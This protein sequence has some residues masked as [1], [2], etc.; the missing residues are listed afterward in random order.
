MG[1]K[2]GLDTQILIYYFEDNKKY[3]EQVEAI[4]LKIRQGTYYGVFSIIGL[5]ELLTGP[6]QQERFDLAADYQQTL[7]HFPNLEIK[8]LTLALVDIASD[9]RAKYRLSTPDAIH[10]AT[11]IDFG[12]DKFITNDR[13]LKKVKEIDIKVL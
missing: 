7:T 5:I 4:L 12:A 9:L 10:L 8:P 13:N 1:Q 2:I 11:A 3:A 6:K